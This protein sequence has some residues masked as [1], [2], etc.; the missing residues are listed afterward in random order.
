MP[1][2]DFSRSFL[3]FRID[4]LKKPPQT[5]SHQPPYSLNNARIQLDCVCDIT[6]IATNQ[7]QRFVLGVNCKT[8]RVGVPSDIWLVPN[9]D[10]VPV[11]S[12]DRFLNLKTY[13]WIGQEAGV[14]LYGHDRQQPDRQTGSTHEAF[15]S[16][17]IHVAEVPGELLATPEAIIAATYSHQPLSAATEYTSG[18]YRVLLQ[19]PVKTFNVNERDNVYQTDTGPVLWPD[20]TREPADLIAGLNL[21][22]TA[23]NCPEWIEAVV[24]VPTDAPNGVK[25]YHYTQSVRLDGVQNRM[26]RVA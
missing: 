12:Q 4:T 20:L 8:E 17:T 16:L 19:Y 21:A 24:R 10:F 25:V 2:I 13:A 7:T 18:R 14:T 6:E 26:Y 15:D 22:F 23:F 5:V 3:T 1:A 11:V 9:A